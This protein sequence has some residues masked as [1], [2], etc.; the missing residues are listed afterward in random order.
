MGWA[1]ELKP[2]ECVPLLSYK[3][4]ADPKDLTCRL[5][6]LSSVKSAQREC[7]ENLTF[8]FRVG[9]CLNPHAVHEKTKGEW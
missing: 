8:L 1:A 5:S 6:L 9:D 3:R 7:A 2:S 4:C